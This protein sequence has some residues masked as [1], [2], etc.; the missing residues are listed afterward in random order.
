M[1]LNQF[2]SNKDDFD[3]N[4]NPE[5]NVMDLMST[6]KSITPVVTQLTDTIP[7]IDATSK[8]T[9][10]R[11][12]KK[13]KISCEPV[14]SVVGLQLATTSNSVTVSRENKHK[15]DEISISEGAK[16]D[17]SEGGL[18]T[19]TEGAQSAPS[20]QLDA[21]KDLSRM[22]KRQSKSKY[23]KI[24]HML[25]ATKSTICTSSKKRIK[26]KRVS[27]QAKVPTALAALCNLAI[28][29]HTHT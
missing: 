5:L 24:H 17:V 22:I 27:M 25:D 11:L 9:T 2:P 7:R 10:G 23:K 26:K 12:N 19:A 18:I 8:I 14:D 16:E 1:Y 15:C 28:D 21:S 6:G 29:T 4:P 13:R 20:L 3:T